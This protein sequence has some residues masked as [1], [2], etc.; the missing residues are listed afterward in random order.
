MTVLA[1]AGHVD[2][3]KSTFVS[4]LTD[5]ETDRL[6]EEKNRG[7]TINLGYTFFNHKNQTYSIVDV[8]GHS[9]F[10]KNTMSG[11]SNADLILF[12]IDASQGWSAQSEQHFNAL[13]EL[14]KKNFI[15]VYTKTDLIDSPINTS[16]LDKRLMNTD[17]L[18]YTIIKFSIKDSNKT[19]LVEEVVSFISSCKLKNNPPSM[20]VD[21]SFSIDGVGAVITGTTSSSFKTDNIFYPIENVKLEIKEVQN[22]NKSYNESLNSKRIALSLKKNNKKIPKRGDLISNTKIDFSNL[23][24]VK[25]NKDL[26]NKNFIKGTKR[27]FIGTTTILVNNIWGI[28]SKQFQYGLIE[29]Q[30]GMPFIKKENFVIQNTESNLFLGGEFYFFIN[31]H[32][33]KK[34]LIN[35]SKEQV[36]INSLFDLFNALEKDFTENNE[37][38]FQ[39]NNWRIKKDIKQKIQKDIKENYKEINKSGFESYITNKYFL[40]NNILEKMVEKLGDMQLIEGQ[41]KLNDNENNIDIEIYEEVKG[42]LG[43]SLDV[44][45]VNLDNYDK[46]KVKSLFL[47]GK[48]FRISKNL[49]ITDF[50]FGLILE[51]LKLLPDEFTVSD[52]KEKTKL[53]RK[54]TIPI[55]ELL[56]KKM[57]TTK[58]DREGKRKKL[59]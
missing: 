29:L 46:E 56:D 19:E 50:H 14:G 38:S 59:L 30:K 16:D 51:I 6:P 52:F 47:N 48:I 37:G 25:F 36:E 22:I 32:P 4:F 54:Y 28:K 8:P 3:G 34:K 42:L 23:L 24:F 44:G 53:S 7:L 35:S 40:D 9:D 11:F 33:L 45:E 31:N 12:I 21:R 27:M 58:V 49:I 39:I 15:F 57:V 10:F 18:N 43:T 5:Q 13:A 55:L 2:H 41:I 17:N 1:T 20:W 26:E